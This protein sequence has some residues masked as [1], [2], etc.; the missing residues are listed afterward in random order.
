MLWDALFAPSLKGARTQAFYRLLYSIQECNTAF[1]TCIGVAATRAG[2]YFYNSCAGTVSVL[3][4]I[5]VP[6]HK[7]TA[8]GVYTTLPM[9]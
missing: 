8:C 4:S 9:Q 2:I 1:S 7:S 6:S 3:R 5:L